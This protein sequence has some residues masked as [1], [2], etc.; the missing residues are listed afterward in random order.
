MPRRQGLM[1]H[2]EVSVLYPKKVGSHRTV[3]SREWYDQ[4]GLAVKRGVAKWQ[5]GSIPFLA[6][7]CL[8]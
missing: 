1:G 8:L 7:F 3:L 5:V 4:M 6:P 2:A